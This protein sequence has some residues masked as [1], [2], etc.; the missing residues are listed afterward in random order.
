[1]NVKFNMYIVLSILFIVISCTKSTEPAD[2]PAGAFFPLDVGMK[3]EY[4]VV[5]S[6]VDTSI[7][8]ERIP[9][10]FT[11]EVIDTRLISDIEYYAVKNFFFPGPFIHDTSYMRIEDERVHVIINEEE[12]LLYSFSD[13]DTNIWHIPMFVNETWLLDYYA[14][15][16]SPSNSQK[17]IL[18]HMGP[19][20]GN[21]ENKWHDVFEKGSGRM[22]IV[23]FSQAFG[24]II[25]EGN[26]IQ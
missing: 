15:R 11:V 26:K 6:D 9:I 22:Q 20:I 3:W 1:M 13:A 17:D 10:D 18:W 21:A 14:T 8:S 4:H 25:W 7:L 2:D 23:N 19:R 12:H 16:S 5:K 24:E